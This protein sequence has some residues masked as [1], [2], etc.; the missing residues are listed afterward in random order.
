[1]TITGRVRNNTTKT[2]S[3]T[4]ITFN[5][6]NASG[7]QV[8]TALANVNGVE[9]GAVWR[10]SAIGFAPEAQRYKLHELSGF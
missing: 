6:Y 7:E 1:M 3:Y 5:L 8:G 10:F 9:P 4:Q 2:Y